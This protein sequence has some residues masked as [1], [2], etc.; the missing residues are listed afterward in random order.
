MEE[1]ALFLLFFL[2]TIFGIWSFV[3]NYK[4]LKN[5]ENLIGKVHY[6]WC[7]KFHLNLP[8]SWLNW[9]IIIFYIALTLFLIFKNPQNL[10]NYTL[11]VFFL[12]V[13]SFAPDW[14]VV[15][16]SKGISIGRKVILWEMIK[17]L[18]FTIK[19]RFLYL[20][21]NW[22]YEKESSKINKKKIPIPLNAKEIIEKAIKRR[23]I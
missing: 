12:V 14:Q 18:E 13:L 11:V 15:V 21:I 22:A 5:R 20:E 10:K 3:S 19:G 23:D 1:P 9:I 4:E 8:F 7:S 2:M 16:G 17:Q 6:R